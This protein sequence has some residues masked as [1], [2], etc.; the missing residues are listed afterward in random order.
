MQE[1]FS[2]KLHTQ[3]L[4]IAFSGPL[5]SGVSD[6]RGVVAKRLIEL[7]YDVVSIKISDLMKACSKYL[8]QPQDDDLNSLQGVERY[9]K[10]QELGNLL[11]RG[12]GNNFL[13]LLV[14]SSIQLDRQRRHPD[15][16][17]DSVKPLRVAYLIDQLKHPEECE[18]LRAVYGDS[19][20]LIGVLCSNDARKQNLQREGIDSASAE[21]IM[22]AD[23]RQDER[24][25]QKLEKTLQLADFFLRN[26]RANTDELSKLIN[27]FLD[28][29]HGSNGVSPSRVEQ[30][31][32]AAYSAA[33]SSAC[34]SRQVG[35]AIQDRDGNIIAKGCNDV[36]RPGGGLY[37]HGNDGGD[38]RCINLRGGVCFN[39]LEKEEIRNEIEVR[40]KAALDERIAGSLKEGLDA[41]EF[42]STLATFLARSIR[43]GSRL[44]D[45]IE[46]SRSVHAEMDALICLAR[47]GR[48]AAMDGVLYTTTYPCHN[49][50]RHIVAAGIRAVYFIE[51]YEKSLAKKLHSD[52]IVHDP[53]EEPT[54]L[55]WCEDS[56]A[57]KKVAFL[58]FE[59]VAPRRYLELFEAVGE[60]KDSRTGKAKD[61]VGR[62]A[63]KKI[64][65]GL[66]GYTMMETRVTKLLTDSGIDVASL[67]AL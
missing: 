59:G 15:E 16:T 47:S 29:I 64:P 8:Q 21:G 10:L 46:F 39:H 63:A 17:P 2:K 28:L 42:S 22:E 45:L 40:I 18:L 30:G 7:G 38:H 61:W 24:H 51:P 4:I 5:G 11:R 14:T 33:V 3:E 31:M 50:A 66:E 25:G 54:L 37:T 60:R 52:A 67:P 1:T 23:R 58:H 35:A 26:S 49:C 34:L 43:D 56:S 62:N 27:R 57:T 9:I 41:R 6:V 19:F 44:K 48:G 13:S 12:R 36:P 65:Q 20:Y 55:S 53:D 32:Y